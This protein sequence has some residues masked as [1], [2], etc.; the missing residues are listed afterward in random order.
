LFGSSVTLLCKPFVRAVRPSQRFSVAGASFLRASPPELVVA[1]GGACDTLARVPH[2]CASSFKLVETRALALAGLEVWYT[3][4]RASVNL[5]AGALFVR[6][7][8]NGTQTPC[9]TRGDPRS[10]EC[11]PLAGSPPVRAPSAQRGCISRTASWWWHPHH[12][13]SSQRLNKCCWQSAACTREEEE[14][15]ARCWSR[16]DGHPRPCSSAIE[17]AATR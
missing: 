1:L 7:P 16:A 2:R 6:H 11:S 12:S 5:F 9:S 10:F 3:R 4:R 8:G 15:D 14:I 13:S 17:E